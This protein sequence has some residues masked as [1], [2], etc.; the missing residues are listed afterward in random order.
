MPL[1]NIQA[2][3][4]SLNQAILELAR[5]EFVF[6]PYDPRALVLESCGPYY[7]D[8]VAFWLGAELITGREE[9]LARLADS[10]EP[11]YAF[12]E[13][14]TM[15][16]ESFQV[17]SRPLFANRRLIDLYHQPVIPRQSFIPR[18]NSHP[19]RSKPMLLHV[20]FAPAKESD[21]AVE[22][23]LS[24]ISRGARVATKAAKEHSPSAS[25]RPMRN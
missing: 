1:P 13:M 9:A 12:L 25:S 21:C 5:T 4:S 10:L 11:M 14:G 15:T 6:G 16:V 18:Q 3:E 17:A 2:R 23:S 22:G 8:E 19:D 24:S 7:G 20:S